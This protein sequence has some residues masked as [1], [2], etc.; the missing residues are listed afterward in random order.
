[1]FVVSFASEDDLANSDFDPDSI[2]PSARRGNEVNSF[3]LFWPVQ[4]LC[5]VMVVFF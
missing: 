2:A 5:L 1:M 3:T 4:C